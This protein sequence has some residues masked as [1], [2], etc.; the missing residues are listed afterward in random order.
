MYRPISTGDIFL[1]A[2]VPGTGDRDRSHNLTMILSHPSAM[3]R[4][5]MLEDIVRGAPIGVRDGLSKT[6]WPRKN[7]LDVFPL[8]LLATIA[9]GNGFE[10]AADGWAALL[11]LAAPVQTTTLDVRRRV[12][13]LSPAG[14]GLLVQ[15][16]VA[17]DT[18]CT[19]NL[20]LIE[21]ALSQKLEEIEWLQD[22]NEALVEPAVQ[23]EG[24]LLTELASAAQEFERVMEATGGD[25]TTSLRHSLYAREGVR[26]ARRALR[27][28]IEA[29]R[30]S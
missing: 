24:D 26:E 27:D 29:R 28:E 2:P 21:R 23:D 12:A 4:G 14:V 1:D 10:L 11:E 25:R 17:V 7:R 18:R 3:R 15:T 5:A 30:P 6:K 19:V 16:I 22:W 8:P 9:N 20:V 13:C